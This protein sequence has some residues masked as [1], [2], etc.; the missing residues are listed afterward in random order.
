MKIRSLTFRRNVRWGAHLLWSL[1]MLVTISACS[2]PVEEPCG[3]GVPRHAKHP[4]TQST[5]PI[6]GRMGE[7]MLAVARQYQFTEVAYKGFDVW[8]KETYANNA[9]A[10]CD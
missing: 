8:K 6:A 7:F 4:Y 2:Q 5:C 3:E 10:R 9:D 1:G